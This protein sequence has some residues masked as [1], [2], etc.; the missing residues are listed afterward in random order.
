MSTK[1][2]IVQLRR[3]L[4][5]LEL[6]LADQFEVLVLPSS[7]EERNAFFERHATRIKGI[8]T[9]STHGVEPELLSSLPNLRIIASFGVGVDKLPLDAARARGIA[10][11]NTPDVL[12]D[13]V[14][15]MAF[16][17]LLDVARRVSQSDRF[18]RA[19]LW[20]PRTGFAPL[21]RQVSHSRLGVVGLGRIGRTVARRAAGFDMIVR[22]HTR[23]PVPDVEWQHV[24]VLTDL[25]RWCDFLVVIVSG[26]AESVH[27]INAAVLEALGPKSFLINVSR[28]SVV[29]E[30]ALIDA[31]QRNAIAGAALDV[32]E[33]EPHVPEAL[34]ALDNVVLAPHISSATTQT[35]EAMAAL[36]LQNLQSFFSSGQVVS[37]ALDAAPQH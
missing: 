32:F 17:L 34:R 27:L 9:T 36:V 3:L 22:F 31:L 33:N 30:A 10:V 2:A 15:D 24:P 12:N 8:V 6:E 28:G 7:A 37:S 18:V 5:S 20:Q 29:D 13:C 4:P 21:G 11:S 25:A 19:G 1:H 26:G 23:R 35:R 16:A 14:A